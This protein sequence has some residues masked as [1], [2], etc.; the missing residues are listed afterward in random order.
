MTPR[1]FN[2]SNTSIVRD[3]IDGKISYKE[4]TSRE[5]MLDDYK[6]LS[7]TTKS[8]S[9]MD[10]FF[11]YLKKSKKELIP[12]LKQTILDIKTLK[13][14]DMPIDDKKG[15]RITMLDYAIRS[16]L[17]HV[18]AYLFSM[19]A[20]V[21]NAPRLFDYIRSLCASSVTKNRL[22][23]IKLV[24]D[25]A[26]VGWITTL[27][28][29]GVVFDKRFLII[30]INSGKLAPDVLS[31]AYKNIKPTVKKD[32]MKVCPDLVDMAIKLGDEEYYPENIKDIF[33]F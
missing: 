21:E 14:I 16:E 1:D 31:K 33:I 23:L 20:K 25:N 22:E 6:S 19:G 13:D 4:V 11:I 10:A 8:I 3:I 7:K 27:Q 15:S 24:T 12:E 26:S 30:I 2:N 28:Y 32:L 9:P 29:A 18:V 5:D 17:N